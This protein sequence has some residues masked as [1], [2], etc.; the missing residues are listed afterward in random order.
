MFLYRKRNKLQCFTGHRCFLK[1]CLNFNKAES[2]HSCLYDR[3]TEARRKFLNKTNWIQKEKSNFLKYL[4]K[5]FKWMIIK[6]S[7]SKKWGCVGP[8]VLFLIIFKSAD[9]IKKQTRMKYCAVEV[10]ATCDKFVEC[11]SAIKTHFWF[12][13]PGSYSVSSQEKS[14]GETIGKR[15]CKKLY[16]DAS[17]TLNSS[18]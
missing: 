6:Q 15:V 5:V 4:S 8:V 18:P 1:F 10:I 17:L 9:T 2:I 13:Q 7:K 12:I 3:C 16:F 14:F 11:G